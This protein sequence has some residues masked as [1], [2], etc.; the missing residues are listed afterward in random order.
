MH[1]R[2][3][4]TLAAF[5]IVLATPV[6]AA[7]NAP[8]FNRDVAPIVFEKCAMCH[9]PG[10]VAPM[11]LLSYDEARPWARSIAREVENTDMPPW[12]GESDN[13]SWSNDISLT[14]DEIETIM[15]WASQGAPEGDAADLPGTPTFPDGW[16]L[17]E[18]DY[19]VTLD[20]VEVW[21]E[22]EDIFTKSSKQIILDKPRWVRAIQFRPGDRRVA[23]HYQTLYRTSAQEGEKRGSSGVFGIWTAGMPPYVFPEGMGRVLG[24]ETTLSFDNH[25]HP[26]G[27]ATT[28][29]S[30]IGIWFGEGPLKKQVS[31]VPVTNT[32]LRIPPGADHHPETARYRFANDSQILAF[33]PHMHVR[34]KAMSYELIYPDGRREMLLDVPKYDYNW[35]WLYYP[36]APIDVPAGSQVEVTAVWDNS[37]ANPA[38]PDP[39]GEI[40]YRGNTFN[41]MF[42]GFIEMI[43]KEG[44]L[45]DEG[46]DRERIVNMLALH[47]PENSFIAGGFFQIG[48]HAPR[49]GEGW[50]YLPTSFSIV[51]DDIRWKGNEVEILTQFP[52]IEASATT[53]LI[54]GTLGEDGV[55]RGEIAV[56]TDTPRPQKIPLIAQPFSPP[57][58][59]Q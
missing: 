31:T 33:S 10:E 45:N 43:S 41:E 53:T 1:R 49:E 50:M 25:Y 35:Q 40:L 55:L 12:S 11:S 5:A 23:H 22:G 46:D 18:P 15:R 48:L 16:A 28:D 54:K 24:K 26:M 47:P 9:R 30:E 4:L 44:V 32:G 27:E 17:G 7:V 42:V 29:V 6:M 36:T 14:P 19:I 38:N 20:P 39:T 37:S 21:A 34:G 2:I 13:H 59:G 52:T 51:L 3:L 57:A 8:T 56:G 58:S